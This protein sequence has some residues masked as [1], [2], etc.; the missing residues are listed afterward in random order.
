MGIICPLVGIV[1]T[2]TPNSGRAKAHP[3]HPLAAS[4]M[5]DDIGSGQ[6]WRA[7]QCCFNS[8]SDPFNGKTPNSILK[9]P[10][11]TESRT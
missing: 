6:R 11:V 3:A 2:D 10:K 7:V 5:G 9:P 8:A 1:L 4:L